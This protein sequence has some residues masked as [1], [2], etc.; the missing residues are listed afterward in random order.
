MKGLGLY[1]AA[2]AVAA[3]ATLGISAQQGGVPNGPAAPIR[4]KAATFTPARG[5]QPSI[6]PG[7]T[8]AGYG[9]AE[10]GYYLVQFS[11]P[12][13]DA[14]KAGVA[15][16][17]AELLDYVPEFAFKARMTPGEAAPGVTGGPGGLRR[18]AAPRCYA[19]F[20]LRPRPPGSFPVDR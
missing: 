4:L 16:T 15:A 7:L 8:I 1:L 9:A 20:G 10:R 11:G 3:S 6:P 18:R 2:A 17:G 12:V 5:E 14:W 19:A 13:L